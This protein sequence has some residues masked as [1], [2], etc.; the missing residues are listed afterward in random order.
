MT[1]RTPSL[2]ATYDPS[3]WAQHTEFSDPGRHHASVHN[4]GR[5]L[6]VISEVSRNL[7]VHYLAEGRGVE[8]TA[9]VA[10]QIN[11]RWIW[12][13][14]DTDRRLN[15]RRALDVPR[16]RGS[17]T[18]GC[19]R[20]HSLLAVAMFR[21]H[22]IPARVRYGYANYLV[23]G[24]SVDHTIVEVWDEGDRRWRRFDP[25]VMVPTGAL[26]E[27]LD[28]PVGEGAPFR[29]AAEVW[30]GWRAGALDPNAYGVRPGG[31]ERGPWFIQSSV[32]RDGAFRARQEPL[33]WDLWGDMSSPGGPTVD[34]VALADRIAA[35]TVAADEGNVGEEERLLSLFSRDERVRLPR[36]VCTLTP[37]RGSTTTDLRQR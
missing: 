29:T 9:E 1:R 10:D 21:S 35:M 17:Q 14:L 32:I 16:E 33:L 6:E 26:Q 31:P 19:C 11:S 34:Q 27:P 4:V 5:E 37:G 3:G 23:R 15:G 13:L 25:E 8:I 20:D 36:L 12:R 2:P 7:V 22:G 28:Q 30:Q 18:R 24:F